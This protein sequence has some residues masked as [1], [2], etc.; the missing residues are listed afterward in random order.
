MKLVEINKATVNLAGRQIFSQVSW[1][2]NSLDRI[3][4]VGPNGAGKSTMFRLIA[5]QVKPDQGT[6]TRSRDLRVAML[7]QFVD[8]PSDKTLLQVALE[9]PPRLA[10]VEDDL[11]DIEIKLDDPA[12]YGDFNKLERVLNRQ[13]EL[14]HEY[15]NLGIER[16]PSL[17]REV[18]HQLGFKPD[19]FDLPAQT[20]SGGQKKLLLLA[21]LALEQPDLILLDEPDNHLDLEA[22][23]ALERFIQKYRGAVV[24]VSHDRYL[25]DEVASQIA[26]LEEG[27]LT[28]YQ[29]NY[30]AYTNER[31]LR[32]LRQQQM[33]AAQQ[34]EITR[35][36]AAIERFEHWA[37]LVVDERHIRQARSRRKMLERMQERG[38]VIEKVQEARVMNIQLEGW[39][40]SNKALEINELRI[41][42]SEHILF[43]S[44]NL[45]VRHGDRVGLVG[46]NGAGK[47]ALFRAVL[48]QLQPLE[49]EINIGPSTRLGYYAQEHQTL[50]SWLERS[51]IDLL[52]DVKPLSE[53][54]AVAHLLKFTFTY[55]QTRQPIRTLSG[56]ERSRL[57]LLSL[58]LTQPN[59][60]LLDEPTNNLDIRS[61]EALETALDDFEGALLIISHDRYFLDQTVD[62]I[63]ELKDGCLT[64]FEGGY[65]DYL[66]AVIEP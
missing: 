63:V 59:L 11:L 47:S 56:G 43:S 57:Q 45:L 30:S 35:I 25:L 26:E 60:L 50:E 5:A 38:E 65:T 6:V 55:E 61:A 15:E 32:R 28:I 12:V 16:Y 1:S 7:P 14:L 42:F 23:R 4:L 19:D 46:P 54:Q 3:G 52:R 62:R 33:Y 10:Q 9:F 20:L 40:G 24:I 21:R 58:M 66:Q 37:A 36:Q 53:N 17:V 41:G 39:R 2:I 51:P 49:G 22:K 64:T 44:L 48:G 13:K 18:L 27:E 31:E 29:G 8:L 34:K